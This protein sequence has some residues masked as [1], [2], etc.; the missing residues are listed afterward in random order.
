MSEGDDYMSIG[1]DDD[2]NDD[3]NENDEYDKRVNKNIRVLVIPF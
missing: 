3:D 2:D 1:D